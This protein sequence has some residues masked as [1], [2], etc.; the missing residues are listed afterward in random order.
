MAAPRESRPVRTLTFLALLIAILGGTLGAGRLWSDAQLAP[1]LALDLEGGTQLILTPLTED[2]S[3]ITDEDI[4]QA[5]S[6]IRQRVDASG[7]AEAEITRQGSQNIVVALPGQ[8]EQATLDLVRQSAQLRF[9]PVIFMG[10]PGPID[11]AAYQDFLQG[12]TGAGEPG[13]AP[14]DDA[15]AA[16]PVEPTDGATDAA[17]QTPGGEATTAPAEDSPPLPTPEEI[18]AAARGAADVNGDGHISSEPE[19]VPA[20]NS[21]P[22]W[23]TEQLNYEYYALNCA[24]PANL[25]GGD[26]YAPDEA[27]VAC[28][29][30]GTVK[31]VL[32][33]A[34][35]E[36][37]NVTTAASGL[38]TLPNGTTTNNWIVTL[39]LDSAGA[40]AFA[41]STTRLS[42]LSE[43]QDRFAVV[44]DGLVIVAP[45]VNEPIPNG[46][47]MISGGFTRESAATLANQLNFGSLPLNFEVQSEEQISATLGIEQLERGLLAGA[48]GLVLVVAYMLSQY[49]ALGLV[50]LGSLVIAALIAYLTITL[51]GWTSGYRLSLAGVAGLI[52]AIGI[53]A[54]SFIVYFERIRDEVREGRPLRDAVEHGWIRA[55]RTIVASDAV[56]LLAAVVLY[57]LAVGG[58][59]GFAFTLGLTTVIDLLV[60]AA[61]THPV[62]ALLIRTRFFG[63]GHPLSGLDPEHLGVSGVAY[64]GRGQFTPPTPRTRKKARSGEASPAAVTPAAAAGTIAERKAAAAR[65]AAEEEQAAAALS[66][67]GDD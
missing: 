14:A 20:D 19:T 33:P 30:D 61:F 27:V 23:L 43:P 5:I 26:T 16:P 18:D 64:R 1:Q 62:M 10:D 31:Y 65:A 49:R 4:N 12:E 36:G 34:D 66:G 38:E 21:D 40:Q 22:A 3:A 17:T 58:V 13:A 67:K 46:E 45:G 35:L 44:L 32:G 57:F 8:P 47:A 29:Q 56:N 11:P 41:D 60:V 52:V 24:D 6:I 42:S 15:N 2:G 63:D 7:V 28:A 9:R 37:T 55:R 48:I 51:L 25:V 50:A 53:T 59:R 39:D 54:D